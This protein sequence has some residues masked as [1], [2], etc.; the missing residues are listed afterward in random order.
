MIAVS[1]PLVFKTTKEGRYIL[2]SPL[3]H[4][5][6]SCGGGRLY[7]RN[8][9]TQSTMSYCRLIAAGQGGGPWVI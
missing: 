4:L 3:L 2:Y 8:Q 9:L 1:L 7:K 6:I 5:E